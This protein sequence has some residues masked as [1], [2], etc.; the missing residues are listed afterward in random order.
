MS[1]LWFNIPFF[2]LHNEYPGGNPL[3]TSPHS[4]AQGQLNCQQLAHEESKHVTK[5]N[6]NPDVGE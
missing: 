3:G 6:M 2:A 4:E 5:W 1:H